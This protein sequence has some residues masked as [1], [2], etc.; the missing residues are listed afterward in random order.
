MACKSPRNRI[1]N[2][3]FRWNGLQKPKKPSLVQ[4]IPR[5]S[6]G[7]HRLGDGR[8]TAKSYSREQNKCNLLI[9]VFSRFQRLIR[10]EWRAKAQEPE[11]G[12]IPSKGKRRTSSSSSRPKNC[13]K[14]LQ[15]AKQGQSAKT[16]IFSRIGIHNYNS[17]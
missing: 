5:V 11:F 3:R 13:Q 1:S 4:F 12:A 16:G 6:A 14:L 10:V 15:G 9:L 2:T 17:S 7:Q 8:K